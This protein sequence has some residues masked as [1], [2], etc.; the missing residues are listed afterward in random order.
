MSGSGATPFENHFSDRATE[1]SAHRPSYPATLAGYLSDLA[2][3][4]ALAWDCGCGSGQLSV[5]LATRFERVV[6]TDASREQLSEAR[7]HPGVH[8]R[9]ELAHASSLPPA[10]TDL[11]TAA[12]AAHWFRLEDYYGEIRRV[13]RPGSAVALISYH[14]MRVHD[15]VD[16]VIDR[17]DAKVLKSH[18]PAERRHVERRY[19]SL[20]F[21]FERIEAPR[22]TIRERRTLSAVLGYIETWSAVRRLVRAEGRERLDGFRKELANAWGPP[23][24]RRSVRWP[25]SLRVGYLRS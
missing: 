9:A 23:E 10:S 11:A 12:Q 6:A 3:R 5:S 16:R 2:P 20:P 7:S 15:R 1:Y 4:P 19:R 21:P 24:E 18:W 17:F 25:L 8:Y 13:G 22:F 14:M